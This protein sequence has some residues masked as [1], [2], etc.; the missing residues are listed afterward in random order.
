MTVLIQLAPMVGDAP[1]VP[2]AV[3]VL[4]IGAI[5]IGGF[6][7]YRRRRPRDVSAE[8]EN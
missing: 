8:R 6:I 1:D 2:F 3:L 5:V 4:V 7:L